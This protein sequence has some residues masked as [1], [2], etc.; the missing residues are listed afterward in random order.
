MAGG[1]GLVL[2]SDGI[3]EHIQKQITD[4]KKFADIIVAILIVIPKWFRQIRERFGIIKKT[5]TVC[6]DK[7]FIAVGY[8]KNLCNSCAR[9]LARKSIRT[10]RPLLPSNGAP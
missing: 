6:I 1:D 4:S 8:S 2:C 5:V 3:W 7:A 9:C 10:L